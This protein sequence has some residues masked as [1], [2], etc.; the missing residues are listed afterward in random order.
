[1]ILGNVAGAISHGVEFLRDCIAPAKWIISDV[2]NTPIVSSWI[3]NYLIMRLRII[4]VQCSYL[5]NFDLY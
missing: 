5:N 1:M 2:I 4:R 3:E